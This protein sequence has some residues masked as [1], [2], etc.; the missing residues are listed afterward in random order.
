VA[1]HIEPIEAE[2]AWHDSELL[3]LEK[4][5]GGEAQPKISDE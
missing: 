5:P 2:A 1:V 3:K 4:Q